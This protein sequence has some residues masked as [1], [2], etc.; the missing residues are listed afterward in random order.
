MKFLEMKDKVSIITP[1]FNSAE[2]ISDCIDSVVNQSYQNWEMI[3]IDDNSSDQ[4]VK[5]IKKKKSSEDRIKLI[6]LKENVGSAMA[7][8]YAIKSAKGR[9]IAFLDS[10]DKWYSN[11]LSLQID[12][13]KTNKIFFSFT[14][15]DIINN[16]GKPTNKVISVPKKISH[17]EYLKNTIIGCLTVIID[18]KNIRI[19]LMKDIRTSHDML[20][21]LDILKNE[22]YAFGLNQVLASYRLSSNSNTKNKLFAAIDVWRVY[23]D[24]ERLNLID[25]FYNFMHYAFNALKKRI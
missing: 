25:S 14:S 24:Y 22:G 8:N 1:C 9:F 16:N 23:R 11:K 4:S 17:S 12:F 13:M 21:W 10:D 18:T 5:L 3:I 15:Y 20:L 6:E 7:R 19:P 2:Y